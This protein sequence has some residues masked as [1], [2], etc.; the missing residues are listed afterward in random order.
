MTAYL[1]DV[2][3]LISLAW[4]EHGQHALVRR[5]FAHHSSKGWATSPMVQ[6]GFVR[7]V[8]NPAFSQRSVSVQEA[9]KGLDASL[10]DNSHQF[11]PDSITF[12]DAVRVLKK[13]LAGHQQITDAYLVALAIHHRGKLATLDRGI[14]SIAPAGSVEVIS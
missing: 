6:A 13:P 3:V 2:N 5:W 11:W 1:L 4:P 8:S 12:T 7:I 10:R 14:S 9:I